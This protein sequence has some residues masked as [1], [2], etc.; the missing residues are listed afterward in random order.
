MKLERSSNILLAYIPNLP[1]V[2]LKKKTRKEHFKSILQI[3][4]N[5][6]E[7]S[8][9]EKV[10]EAKAKVKEK[11]SQKGKV[12]VTPREDTDHLVVINLKEEMDQ[13]LPLVALSMDSERK[14]P[15]KGRVLGAKRKVVLDPDQQ[16]EDMISSSEIKLFLS[17]SRMKNSTVDHARTRQSQDKKSKVTWQVI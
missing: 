17:G 9:K 16:H 7:E 14:N 4:R 12:K 11:G 2:I 13:Q 5:A 6:L 3:T 1:I 8:P 15:L 10:R